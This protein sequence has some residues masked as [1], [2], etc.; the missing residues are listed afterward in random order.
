MRIRNSIIK[1]RVLNDILFLLN[2]SVFDTFLHKEIFFD[3]ISLKFL[4]QSTVKKKSICKL[5]PC[6]YGTVSF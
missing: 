4:K 3:E 2:D 5:R 1:D 6:N